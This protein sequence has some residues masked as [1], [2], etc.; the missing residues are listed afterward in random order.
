MLLPGSSLTST[1]ASFSYKSTTYISQDSVFV[2]RISAPRFSR[3]KYI[4][5]PNGSATRVRTWDPL[6][7]SQLLYQLSYRGIIGT[8]ERIRTSD[9]LL[10]RQL[11]YPTELRV[12][13]LI[14]LNPSMIALQSSSLCSAEILSLSRLRF[15]GAPGGITRL[16]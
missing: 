1:I 2:L 15:F 16:V 6:I 11:L 4:I 10:R 5:P 14:L 8:P 3:F 7:N 13:S 9:R 12:H